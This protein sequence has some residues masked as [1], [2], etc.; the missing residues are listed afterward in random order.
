MFIAQSAIS[1]PSFGGGIAAGLATALPI[2]GGRYVYLAVILPFIRRQV[3]IGVDI[4]GTWVGKLSYAADPKSHPE[5]V[6]HC[7]VRLRQFGQTL[8]GEA[9]ATFTENAPETADRVRMFKLEGIHSDSV[10]LL[11]FI[12]KNR[13]R[14]G[15]AGAVFKV[16][17][18]GKALEGRLA[19]YNIHTAEA[20]CSEFHLVRK[21]DAE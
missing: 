3:S 12:L 13:R 11:T 7:E 17:K 19:Y 4:S 10:V 1:W 20:D 9:S 14:I 6:Q 16:M 5:L 2:A 15:R 8:R 21:E 18:A